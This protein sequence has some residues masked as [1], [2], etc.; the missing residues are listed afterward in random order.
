MVNN[1]GLS[2]FT[3]LDIYSRKL[4]VWTCPRHRHLSWVTTPSKSRYITPYLGVHTMKHIYLGANLGAPCSP[5][6][7]A[8]SLGTLQGA[9]PLYWNNKTWENH[10]KIMG[11]SLIKSILHWTFLEARS[12]LYVGPR[13]F[14]CFRQQ[15]ASSDSSTTFAGHGWWSP[16]CHW[17]ID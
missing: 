11:K 9:P 5:P 15:A 1:R 4:K 10:G 2:G 3:R 17:F 13:S 14:A 12:A 8:T 6:R 7:S 16:T